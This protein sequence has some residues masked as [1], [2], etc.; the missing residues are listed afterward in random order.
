MTEIKIYARRGDCY[1]PLVKLDL[2]A[3]RDQ[4]FEDQFLLEYPFPGDDKNA[5]AETQK[6]YLSNVS[7]TVRISR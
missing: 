6:L 7:P 5:P 2:T 4:G 3:I 1:F